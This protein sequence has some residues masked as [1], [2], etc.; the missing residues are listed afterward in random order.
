MFEGAIAAFLNRLL[1]RY[2]EDLDTEQFNVG[3]FSGDTCLTDLK[4]KP[5]AL[6]QL[7]LPIRVEIGLIGKIILKIPWSGLFSQPIVICIEDVYAVAVPALSGPYDPEIQ[8]RLI[9]AEKKKILEDLKEDDIFRAG[10]PPQLFDGLLASVTKN[11]QITINNVHIRYE[12]KILRNFLCACGICIQSISITTTN[13][14]WKP[15]VCATNSQTV[16]QLIRAESLSVYMDHDTE[17]CINVEGNW[18]MSTLLAW[19]IT[20]HRA[21][22]TFGMKNKEFQFL[23]KPFTA[24]I[25][26]IIHKGTE[27]QASRMLV[28]IVLQDVAMQLSE[29]QYATFCHIYDSLL[30][31]TINR[32][33]AKYRPEK[34]V[35]EESSAWWKYAYNF[36]LNHYI[37]PY[38]W[39]HIAKHRE[40]YKKYKETCIQ[41]LQRPN[42]TELKLD[43]QKHEDN[44]TILN[45]VIARE[46]ARQELRNKD[47]ERECQIT[48]MSSSKE[49]L[50]HNVESILPDQ[51][52]DV[53]NQCSKGENP[54]SLPD[55]T[56]NSSISKIKEKSLKQ[57]DYKLNFTLANCCLSLLSKGK[58]MLIVTVTQFLTSVEARPTLLAFKIS[59]RAES[60]V[61]EAIS[62]DGDL[63][64]L[65]TVDNVLT[66]N[67]STYFLAIDFEKNGLNMDPI[68]E[69]AI[70]LE[71]IEVTYHHF[72]IVEIINFFKFNTNYL[73]DTI[74]GVHKLWDYVKRRYLN[75]VDD[76]VS[77]TLRI[78]FKIDIKSPY[79]IFPEHGSIQKGGHILVLDFGNITLTN[80]LQAT[81]LQLEDATLMELEELL[82]DRLNI[83]FSGAQILFCHSGDDW[84]SV[85]K[86]SDSEYHLLP[87]L[88][89][90]VTLSY[91]IR[92]EYRQ[93]PR[94]KLNVHISNMKF[95]L[96]EN[97]LRLLTYFLNKLL[98]L[99]ENNIE[100]YKATIKNSIFGRKSSIIFISTKELMKVQSS[101]CLPSVI[102]MHSGFKPVIKEVV[103]NNVPKLDRSVVSSEVSEEDLELLSKTI[104]LSGFDDNIS[105]CN[106]I[107]LLLRFA[108][109][110]FSVNL[111]DTADNREQPYLNLR[112]HTLYYET[113][114]MEYGVAVQFGIGS[115]F[116]VD[117]TNAGITG[118][119]LEL[120]STDESYEV[121]V[122]SYRK[123]KSNCP[124]FKSHFKNIERSLIM[125]LLNININFHKSALLKMKDYWNKFQA[126]CHDTLVSKYAKKM[127]TTIVKREQWD[128][129]P[130]I[131]PGAIKLNYS[132]RLSSLVVRFCDKDIDLMEIKILGLENDCIY[133]A[134]ERMVLRVHLR[135]I[136]AEDLI[137][138]TLYSRIL[139][140]DEDKVFDLK[141]VRHTPRL[142]KCSDIDTNQDDVMSDGTFKLSIGRINCVII[143]KILYDLRNFIIPFTSVYY[144]RF[145]YY[146]KNKFVGGIE[147]FKRS[148]TKLHIFIDI[149]GPTFLLP[150]KK[151]APSLLVFDTGILSVENFFKNSKQSVK[152]TAGDSNSLIID[153]I[154]VKLKSMTVSRAIMTLTRD[155]EVQEPIIE[156]IQIQF[157]IKRKTE[158]RSIIEF[159]TYGL[160]NVQGAIDIININLSQKD[161]KSLILVWQDNVSKIP[162][163]KKISENE[164]RILMQNSQKSSNEDDVMV[165][166]L[167]NFLTHNETALCEIN[168]KLTLEGLQLN[169]FMDTEEVLSSPVRDLNHGL[170]K[171]SFGETINTWDF[172]SDKSLKMKLSLQ[173]CL[174]QDTR[175]DLVIEKRIIQSPAI[176]LEKNLESFISVSMSP[177]IDV[178]YSRTQA[179]EKC[180][181]VLIQDIRINLS[182]PFLMHLGRYFLDS[183]PGEQI[184]KGIINHGYDN[185][186]QMNRNALNAEIDKLNCSQYFKEQPGTSISVRIQKPDIFLFGD[187][188][189][190]NTHVIRMQAEVFIESSRHSRSSSIVCT[191]TNINAKTKRQGNYES[192]C[193]LLCPCDI[194]I[195]KK[196]LSCGNE[197]I[198]VV[199]NNINV[200]LSAEVIHTFVDILN[201]ASTFLNSINSKIDD[202]TNQNTNVHNNLWTSRKVSSIPY[203]K[204]DEGDTELY[205]RRN[206]HVTFNL[207]PVSICLLLEMEHAIGRVPVMRMETVVTTTINDWRNNFHLE[208]NVKLHAFCYN[209]ARQNWE[210]FVEFCTKDD[211]NYK[212]W[213]FTIKIYR[214]EASMIN[215]NWMDPCRDI[216]QDP[217]KSRKKD[218]QYNGEDM[219]DMTFIGP[220]ADMISVTKKEPEIYVTYEDES[221]TDDDESDTKLTKISSYLFSNNSDDEESDSD[222]SSTNE[223]EEFE[224][225]LDC[226]PECYNPDVH[227]PP[228]TNCTASHIIVYSEDKV[229]ITI[230]QDM[231]TTWNVILN[232][233]TQAR[234]GIPFVPANTRELTV[235]NDIGHAS[236]VELL[237]QE[238]VDGKSDTRVVGAYS[239][240]DGSS[241]VSVPSSPENEQAADLTSPQWAGKETLVTVSECKVFPADSPMHVYKL[242]TSELLRI[243]FDG[244]EDVLVYCPKKEARNLV[245]LRPVRHE[246]RYYLVIEASINT[247]LHRTICVRSPLQFRNETS[248]AL[249]LYYKKAIIDKLGLTL[250]GETTNP[251]DHNVRM[252][253]IEPDATYNIP[254]YIA[255]HC[256]IHVLPAYLEKYQISEEGIYWRDMRG[257]ANAFKDVCCEAKGDNNRNVFCVR[258]VCTEFPLMTRPSG[259]Q[260]PNYLINIVPPIIFNNQLPFVI[261]V[262]IPAINYEVKIEP[263]EKI[264]MHSLNHSSN[265]HFVFKI[266]NYLGTTW[267]GAVKLNMNLERK[268]VLMSTDSESDLTK[269]FLLCLELCKILSW[270]IIIQSQ[271]WIINKSGLPL[272]VQDCH[273]HITY[274]MPEEELMVFSQKNNKKSMVQLR[275]H[276]SE[277]SVP[278]GLDGITS[279]S[280]IVC[281]DIERGRKYQILTEI[282][283]S[284]L[285]PIFTKIITFLPY[286][287]I[288]NK[289]KRALRFM[290]E[291]E[292]ADLW[293]DLLPGQEMSFWPAT[294]S[295]K[296]KIKWRNSQLVSQHFDITHMGKTVLRMDNGSALCVEIEGGVNTPYRITFRRYITGDIPV[297]VDNLCDKLFLKLNQV[298]LGQV[299]LLKPFQSL[300]YT[301]DDPTQTR[302]LIWNVYSNNAIGYKAQFETDGYGHEKVSF[303]TI[304]RRHSA[305]HSSITPKSL[306]NTKSWSEDTNGS[307]N[308]GPSAESEEKLQGL[309][310]VHQ[311]EAEVYWV[312]YMEGDQRVLLF[313][314]HES[315]YLKARSIIDPEASKREIFLSIAAIGISIIV[316]ESN[317]HN[318]RR[319][320]LYASVIDSAANWELYFSKRWRNL[321][322]ELTAWLENK[323]TN[324][325]K[326]AQ[327]ENFIDV[328]FTKMQMTKPFFGKLRRTYSPGIW[329][330]CRKSTTL[331]YLQGYVHRIQIDNQLSEA[332]FPVVLYSNLQKTFVN[333]AGS[334]RLKHCLEFSYLKQRKLRNIIYKGICVI[335]R[336]FNLNLE[337]TFLCSLIN[338][339]PKT[340]ETKYSIAAKLRRD[341][342]NMRVLS[343]TN[344]KRKDLIEQIYISPMTLRLKLLANTDGSNARNFSNVLGYHNILRFIFEYAERGTFERNVEFR[345]PHYRNNFITVDSKRFLSHL[346]RVYVAQIMEQF[347]VLVRFTTVLGNQYGYN[348]KLPGSYFCEPD[349]LL[350]CGDESAEKLAHEVAC[351][352][353]HATPDGTQASFLSGHDAHTLHYKMKDMNYRNPDVQSS[354]FLVDHSFATEIDLETS[355]LITTSTNSIHREELRYFFKTLGKKTSVLF[356]A[357]SSCLKTYSKVIANIIKRAQEMGLVCR[358][359]L[360]R[361]INPHFGVE[362][363]STHKAKGM[364]LLNAISTGHCVQNDSYW[365]H[366]AL[367]DDGKYITL[368]SLQRIYYIEKG[369]T[370]GSW[371]VKW[372]LETNQLLSPPTVAKN[373]LVLH[374]TENEEET[375][376][377][378]VDWYVE[379]EAT[380]ILEW[381]CRKIN[382]AM[383][384]NMESSICSK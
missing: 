135:N 67:V 248:Y 55:I 170:C 65:I 129:D 114:M 34:S 264:N 178:T 88:Q 113:A 323:Y 282:E 149:Q 32:P 6:Y 15:G 94:T 283:S 62:T 308:H 331:C 313:T 342:S 95:N 231:I 184:E 128:I 254:L 348:F 56:E 138:D 352:L 222:D 20:M 255:Y 105:P 71:A 102:V 118:S 8:K 350:M 44:L 310:H 30:R 375:S 206:D 147:L 246:V 168:I 224:L 117:K 79:I 207:R 103:T 247:Y 252:A 209:R 223:D 141:Y 64:P 376:S 28:D 238:Q 322:L 186:N 364:Y 346:S 279:M 162:L 87:K 233:F 68:F 146:L 291:N 371:N 204:T 10:L 208:S 363:F 72:A 48:T 341:V 46:H 269:P 288:C 358:V 201:E 29:A 49:D 351:E 39:S 81:N 99:Y 277:W 19:K 11:F 242:I 265:V 228:K 285:S 367:H 210:P 334:R 145:L 151:D 187:L 372:T 314:Q 239:F 165:K 215:S 320:L 158:Y 21:L 357:E 150:Q 76:I 23:L 340:P 18:D 196:K 306:A 200:H 25:K 176:S 119:Y 281:R 298:D 370:W 38:T 217:V 14:K 45:V 287:F 202:G 26:V 108:I 295:M 24:K 278:F 90:N 378:M 316:Q 197:E 230:T 296:M 93:L 132:T 77:Q 219:T 133:N 84:R 58:E 189:K 169:L 366:A 66:G 82:Y 329:L 43:M 349:L 152:A 373:K 240:H 139:T 194:E 336:E 163:L 292:E 212:P 213:E 218:M 134:N 262:N 70:K 142:Y 360:P 116:L 235:L 37:K 4:L 353:G 167:E 131:P 31:A 339:V 361:Y 234:G 344:G 384:L 365:G 124:D 249:G 171:L 42:D 177:I 293:N 319:E 315:V 324:S 381:L 318:V 290:E 199:I 3:I 104:N 164:D 78:S 61:I 253:I 57:I 13:N 110:E 127:C 226:N 33:Y 130:P 297:R 328:D 73:H 41:S 205:R 332:T 311:G 211:A 1:G 304:E 289:T 85:R 216:K 179:E 236:R 300:L 7:G 338:L 27:T 355:G 273:S 192:P 263:G 154:L 374:L 52:Q 325:T 379:S 89:A 12:E 250:T 16:Y 98:V 47:M 180:F 100:K 185:N 101:V 175:K 107:N 241:P 312:S 267:M 244:F 268:F 272:F 243:V 122:V 302:E 83:M 259:C 80:E 275:A 115:I 159:H 161:L 54:N 257:T 274:E 256:P 181:D 327:L 153:N 383:I 188:E 86:R 270:N 369:S 59:V 271:Y 359:R 155:L 92:P 63:V 51:A 50:Q 337:E 214:G 126:V 144:T 140:T 301:W 195:C 74:R 203:K 109:G 280:L 190:S 347:H 251:F 96:S 330:H 356:K 22:Q 136:L 335:I 229:N 309:E 53:T 345:L 377:S 60:F 198:T 303:V 35:Y 121:L 166:K 173:S 317:L 221:D 368:V 174:L 120:I 112:M 172:Y 276:Q 2:V 343:D 225:I 305:S 156:P 245:S 382:N 354:A 232:A 299:A 260:V 220:D 266:H 160:F 123:V 137:N 258:A 261:D 286:F 148:A 333:Y 111:E 17:S 40:N 326:M 69:V 183:L 193:W 106:H 36:I 362:S 307:V 75:F 91:S 143:S 321:S 97:K 182:V 284:R 5:E 294:E 227:A 125:N 157:D 191:L 380:D 237:V 9:R